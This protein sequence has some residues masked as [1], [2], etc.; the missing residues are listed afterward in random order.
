VKLLPQPLVVRIESEPPPPTPPEPPAPSPWGEVTKYL[1]DTARWI[2]GGIIATAGAVIA[3]SS[4]THLGQL[5]PG[6]DLGRLT[7]AALGAAAGF[8]AIGVLFAVS[9]RIFDVTTTDLDRLAG[10]QAGTDAARLKAMID[11][12][13]GLPKCGDGSLAAA[14]ETGDS[15]ELL[16]H[17]E[18]MA[19]YLHVR[20]KFRTMTRHLA[21]TVPLAA[22]G[23]GTFAWA[24]NP[25]ERPSPKPRPPAVVLNWP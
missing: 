17:V 5:D 15:E 9:L 16:R 23:F 3:G 19:P 22:L 20:D 6:E 7:V 13:F 4:L 10:A 2:V 14:L 11:A 18:A 25:P 8:A 1:R 12:E 24:A 21:W